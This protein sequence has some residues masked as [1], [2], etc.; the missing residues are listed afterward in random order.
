MKIIDLGRF[1]LAAVFLLAGVAKLA[2]LKG[3]RA[4]VRDFGVPARLAATLGGLL[5]A[6]E[7]AIAALL[8]S[9][10]LSWYG[11]W[12]AAALLGIF[13]LAIAVNLILGR[14]PDCHCFGQLH[15]APV[16]G[17]TLVRNA[18]LAALA[19]WLVWMGR[20][21]SGPDLWSWLA[22][23]DS[24][25]RRI[26][27][28]TACAACFVLFRI[29]AGTKPAETETIESQRSSER[30]REEPA[31]NP[32]PEGPFPAGIGLPLGTPAPEFELP[33]LDGR[34][35]SFVS[36]REPGKPVLLVFSSP[37]CK[38]CQTLL[39]NLGRWEREHAESLKII[40][41]SR[42]AVEENRTKV[43]DTGISR[44][45]LQRGFEVASAYDCNA[46]PSAVLI[47]AEGVIRSEL[48]VG[49]P[50]IK[51]LISS[52]AKL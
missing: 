41:I 28:I 34:K 42:G 44:V 25:G 35:H 7:I 6:I 14:K 51:Q 50:A 20:P 11:A 40:L 2:D 48:A 13:L 33:D 17:T 21:Q 3:T 37:Y 39:P 10:R 15:S 5:P 36:V 43:K 26:A 23:L 45:L 24:G 52:N 46:T 12:A 29:V 19:G 32:I 22:S 31:E 16:S 1:I 18:L 47:D 4:A 30:P 27:I 49:G 38:P 9:V 8:V